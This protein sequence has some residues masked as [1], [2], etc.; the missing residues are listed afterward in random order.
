MTDAITLIGIVLSVMLGIITLIGLAFI[1]LSVAFEAQSAKNR[2]YRSAGI[3]WQPAVSV[4][5]P[6]YNEE[7]VIE[8]CVESIVATGYPN[9]EVIIVDDG[10]VDSTPALVKQLAARHENVRAYLK[11]N[12]GKGSALNYGTERATGEILLYVDADGIFTEDTIP[13]MLIAFS[14]EKIG[15]ICGN[16]SPVNLDR[17]QTRFLSLV[18]HV[19]TG[20]VRRAMHMLRCVPVI[21]GNCGAFRASALKTVEVKTSDAPGGRGPLRTDTVGEDLEL[22]W[23][24]YRAGWRVAFAPRAIVYAESPSTLKGLWN[25]RVRWAR[26]MLQSMTH[27]RDAIGTLKF[28]SFGLLLVYML[29]TG[30]IFPI[31][32]ILGFFVLPAG[33]IATHLNLPISEQLPDFSP[34]MIQTGL[35]GM[36]IAL[37]GSVALVCYAVGLDRD[38]QHLKYLWL[39]PLWPV[40]SITMSLVMCKAIRLEMSKAANQW[41]KLERTGVV[42]VQLSSSAH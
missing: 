41:N 19:G 3:P 37:L 18:S 16:D 29:V 31:L 22:T 36:A 25:Q 28:G 34:E 8:N 33:L 6:A 30:I 7:A 10:S 38:W 35:W 12:G 2:R 26:G 15:A 32:Q 13:E 9:L 39:L 17:I 23:R 14:N 20:F 24:L 27:H 5:V 4:I 42:T 40:Y 1:P 21:S 11:P